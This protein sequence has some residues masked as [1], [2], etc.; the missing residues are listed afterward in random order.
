MFEDKQYRKSFNN[1]LAD[2]LGPKYNGTDEKSVKESVNDFL[3]IILDPEYPGAYHYQMVAY[4]DWTG[5]MG[6]R[7]R[8]HL[9]NKVFFQKLKGNPLN[10]G[11]DVLT[12]LLINPKVLKSPKV[13]PL[14]R[15]S[16]TKDIM[17]F[18]NL[19][20]YFFKF[21][22][23]LILEFGEGVRVLGEALLTSSL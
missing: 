7:L 5:K 14:L 9:K 13:N 3:A 15:M 2:Y 23:C 18:D 16:I 6:D 22:G 10:G 4:R 20:D 12:F 21:L 19:D 17:D 1:Y 11:H 8:D